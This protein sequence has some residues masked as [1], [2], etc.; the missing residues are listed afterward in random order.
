[1]DLWLYFTYTF[2]A[3]VLSSLSYLFETRYNYFALLNHSSICRYVYSSLHT[4]Q[5]KYILTTVT[6][7]NRVGL[8]VGSSLACYSP[9]CHI[10]AGIFYEYVY[11]KDVFRRG[12]SSHLLNMR[13][14]VYVSI[15]VPIQ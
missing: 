10:H 13:V 5:L 2:L 1:M 14:F 8:V 15:D 7:S 4:L 3:S 12:R 11:P 6:T 9:G